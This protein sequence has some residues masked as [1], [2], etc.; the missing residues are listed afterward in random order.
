[1]ED[2]IM[3]ELEFVMDDEVL[4]SEIEEDTGIEKPEDAGD[5]APDKN[6][7][8]NPITEVT[9]EEDNEITLPEG[10]DPT[11]YGIYQTMVDKG[12]VT[13][14]EEFKGTYEELDS[15]FEQLPEQ[16]WSAV[17]NQIPEH[18]QNL[19]NFVF[20]KGE[21]LTESDLISFFDKVR[22][23]N[24]D[25]DYNL[26][27]EEDQ[28]AF[29]TQYFKNK[30]EDD[31]DIADRIELWQEKEKLSVKAKSLHEKWKSE[32]NSLAENEIEQARREKEQKKEK[33]RAFKQQLE[34]AISE[35]GWKET[36]QQV[37]LN[38]IFSGNLNAKTKAIVQH[39]T[40][41]YH[42][43]DWLSYYD[44]ETGE[45]DLE[46]Y[47]KRGASPQIQKVKDTISRNFS[48]VS[49]AAKIIEEKHTD[50]GNHDF[51]FVD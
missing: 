42:L 13:E 6:V 39:P 16:L 2:D 23:V 47:M 10:A 36:R 35:S 15:M 19:L 9:P 28:V 12:Y 45:V 48:R 8:D 22:P 14:S 27:S 51:E 43:A 29:L 18:G 25:Q 46:A 4:N 7:D 41:L 32:K 50:G 21:D 5:D 3:P 34:T 11:A 44:P 26:E 38:E 24:T 30:G 17:V 31:D 20:A 40:A 49:K 1:M 37:V 33:A